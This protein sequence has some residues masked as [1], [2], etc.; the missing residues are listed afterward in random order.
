MNFLNALKKIP[1]DLGQGE[2][3]NKTKGKEIALELVGFGKGKT[4]LDVG[5]GKGRQ[6]E[7][8]KEKGFRVIS[9][10]KEK[11]YKDCRLVDVNSGIPFADNTFDLI[12]ASEVIEHLD[13]PVKAISEFFRVLKPKGKLIIT[14]PNSY[15]ILMWPFH[16]LGFKPKHLQNSDH[17]HFFKLR[18]IKK[19]FPGA[20]IYGYF[21]YCL[22][23][24]KIKK[25][26]GLLSPT[27]IIEITKKNGN[28]G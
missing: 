27:F 17:K 9:I 22:L 19:L 23:K 20:N 11:K 7:F 28:T 12:W 14:T 21:P 24:F 16:L 3:A 15:F 4:A 8:L 6:S 26:V 2:M 18:D 1:L 10:D 25:L 5:C 13:S